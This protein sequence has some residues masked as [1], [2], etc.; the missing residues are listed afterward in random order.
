MNYKKGVNTMRTL[1][2][3]LFICLLSF[4]LV[5]VSNA[6]WSRVGLPDRNVTDIAL[7]NG[8]IFA[9]TGD[10]GSVYRSTNGGAIWD[11]IVDSGASDIA[12]APTGTI[13]MVVGFSMVAGFTPDSLFTSSNGGTTW[14]NLG[15]IVPH[16]ST[17]LNVAVSPT[18]MVFCGMR[19]RPNF[20]F[21]TSSF[22]TSRD[23]GFLWLS[24]GQDTLGGE[25]VAFR[26]H[27]VLT[28]GSGGGLGGGGAMHILSSDD[29]LSW[30]TKGTDC[31]FSSLAWSTN[32]SILASGLVM[33]YPEG[34]FLSVDTAA[35]WTKVSS[36]VSSVLFALPHDGVLVGTDT[37]G[38]YLFSDNGDSIKTLNE[39]LT[40]LHV[41]TL[42]T[43]STQYVY[44]G[45][46]NGVWR[47]PL[48]EIITSVPQLSSELPNAYELNQNYPNPFNPSTTISYQLPATS[49]VTLKLFDVLGRE[50]TT[51]V[52]GV[53]EP[54][55][56]LVQWNSNGMGSGVY[57]YRLQAGTF[58]Q[59]KKLI[60]LR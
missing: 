21:Y 40:D 43:D 54:G 24:P 55:Y 31:Y 27:S 3:V 33:T 50:I 46:N 9:V 4:V 25:A 30:T 51:L 34:L 20:G 19:W 22:I 44:A 59:T 38:I 37:I 49:L 17:R 41:H 47:R 45:T 10:S 32:G 13:Y 52:N 5:R 11:Q 39:G 58:I 2:T 57:F 53:E 60:L 12:L 48:S 8:L 7:G 42:T 35:T 15:L 14:T 29:G 26:G 18:G 6:Q 23:G 16:A 36:I 56:K 28:V 1:S